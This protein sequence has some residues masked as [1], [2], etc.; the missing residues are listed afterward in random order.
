MA[1]NRLGRNRF[2]S[3]T[4]EDL[5]LTFY[6]LDLTLE[7][8]EWTQSSWEDLKPLPPSEFTSWKDVGKW[9]SPA[10]SELHNFR[11]NWNGMNM[12]LNA[13]PFPCLKVKQRYIQWGSLPSDMQLM[14]RKLLLYN[15]MSWNIVGTA[16]GVKLPERGSTPPVELRVPLHHHGFVTNWG[17][18]MVV[19]VGI[20]YYI[21]TA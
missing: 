19:V 11:E 17:L 9:E 16:L 20:L 21:I 6:G 8:M 13:S 14:A 18:G 12:T 1:H 3:Y 4:W 15:K 5:T 7:D 2:Q 10:T